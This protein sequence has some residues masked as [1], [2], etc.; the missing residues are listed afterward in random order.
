M[1]TLREWRLARL[2]S[3]RAL[4]AAS[5]V[6]QKTIIDIEYGRRRP[7]YAT[8]GKLSQALGVEPGE[9]T[10]LAAALEELGKSAA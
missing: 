8:I 7:H 6:T 3:T 10:E 1:K 5:G 9:V 2:M 4:E